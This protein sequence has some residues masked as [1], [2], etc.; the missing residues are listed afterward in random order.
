MLNYIKQRNQELKNIIDKLC[1]YIKD[2]QKNNIIGKLMYGDV[3]NHIK[4]GL[5]N[6]GINFC[7]YD[8]ADRKYPFIH[9]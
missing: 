4:S 7:I 1:D 2:E 6:W 3:I 8:F 9:N 5:G